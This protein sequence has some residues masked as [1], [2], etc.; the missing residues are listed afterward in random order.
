MNRK[1][2]LVLA[3]AVALSL[4]AAVSAVPLFPGVPNTFGSGGVVDTAGYFG[5]AGGTQAALFGYQGSEVSLDA[6]GISGSSLVVNLP[7][8][9]ATISGVSGLVPPPVGVIMETTQVKDGGTTAFGEEVTAVIGGLFPTALVPFNHTAPAGSGT[10]DNGLAP[11]STA[12]DGVPDQLAPGAGGTVTYALTFGPGTSPFPYPAPPVFEIYEDVPPTGD[13]DIGAATSTLV[14]EEFDF[15]GSG[16]SVPPPTADPSQFE[17]GADGFPLPNN[18]SDATDGTLVAAGFIDVAQATIT[19]FDGS[20]IGSGGSGPNGGYVYKIEV[21][22]K[23]RV[24]DGAWL[25][26]LGTIETGTAHDGGDINITFAFSLFGEAFVTSGN[27]STGFAASD[28]IDP[29]ASWDIRT[30]LAG[31]SGDASFT[32][33]PVEDEGGGEGCTPGFWRQSQHFV[34]WAETP[35]SPT[36]SYEAVFGVDLTGGLDGFT[37]LD[38]VWVGG[39]GANRLLRHSVAALLNAAHPDV[40]YDF[41][42]AEVIAA[43]QAAFASGDFD[44]VSDVLEEANE[45][46]CD[47]IKDDDD[48]DTG[49]PPSP[50]P[51]GGPPHGPPP[52]L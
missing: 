46:G 26:M 43:V 24:T 44:A 9:G 14:E 10:V 11:G 42:E 22:A 7:Q 36:D 31:N 19:F 30:S 5:A 47:D 45:Q 20:V 37:L 35:Y 51:P 4:A 16:P 38:A 40:N 18:V 50:G 28:G 23:G 33:L 48:G 15:D 21:T 12:G 32:I 25:P 34:F 49:P 3:V 39:G 8:A 1:A 29:S 52:S 41:T 27:A 17:N 13:L 2:V 6:S